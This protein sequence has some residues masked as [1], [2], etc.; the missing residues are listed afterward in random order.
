M[1]P[2]LLLAVSWAQAGTLAEAAARRQ[3]LLPAG[4]IVTGELIGGQVSYAMAGKAPEA[5]EAKPEQ[6]VFEIGSITKVF[7][8]LLLAQAVVEKKVTLDTTIGSLLAGK[9][10]F[11]DPRVAAITLRQ[12][13]THTSG[14]PCLPENAIAGMAEDDPYANYDEKLLWSYLATAKLEGE[15]PFAFGY[16]NLGMGLLGHLLGGVCQT[17]WDKA[18]VEKICLPL[19]MKDTAP[20]PEASLPRAMPHDG[21]KATKPWHM[22]ALAGCGALRSTAADLMKFG[23]ALLHP[24]QTPLK[25]AFAL[26]LK[27]QADAPSM[28]GQIGL[29]VLLGKFDGD[30]TLHHDGGTGGFCS[31]LQVIPASGIVRVVL[32][33]SNALGGSEVIAGTTTVKP[34]DPATQKETSLPAEMLKQYPGL[35]ELDRNSSFIVKLDGGNLYLKL[36]GQMFLRLFAK[37]PDRFFMKEVAAEVGF[38]RA[39]G[40]IRSVTLFQNGNEITAKLSA[41]P[42]PDYKLG[43]AKALQAYAGEYALMGMQKLTVSVKGRTLF[44]QMEGQPAAPVFETE[45]DRFEYDVVQAALVFTRDDDKQING[46]TLL[47][48][49][50]TVPAPRVKTPSSAPKQ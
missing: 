31:G 43:S 21:A 20:Q 32:I 44:A 49:G 17:S 3:K 35:Y 45:A 41:K 33:N 15:S 5:G 46:L 6:I 38:N 8:G 42:P 4:C 1:L 40:A 25:E 26:A 50:L 10:K 14:L 30:A 24:D 28:G 39:E 7:T 37:G 16:S 22:A 12:L 29:G 11:A 34:F 18:V 2:C 23:E 13:A 19:G 47:Q 27:P 36:T 48:N 9:V